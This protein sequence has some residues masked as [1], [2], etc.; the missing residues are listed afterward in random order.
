M[1]DIFTISIKLLLHGE[2]V[3]KAIERARQLYVLGGRVKIRDE[4]GERES[5]ED[6]F[7]DGPEQALLELL[8]R[9]ELFGQAGVE[10]FKLTCGRVEAEADKVWK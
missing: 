6:E 10:V 2:A 8:E 9:N 3:T 5:T 1:S 4:N 7:I